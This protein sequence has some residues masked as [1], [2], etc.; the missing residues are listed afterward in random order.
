MEDP[1]SILGLAQ[2]V[3]NSVLLWP[4]QNL[5]AI[6]KKTKINQWDLIK[7]TS[8]CTAN[9]AI[10]KKKA[11]LR[12]GKKIVP[13]Y[14]TDKVFNCKIYKQHTT[15]QQK[16]SNPTEKQAGDLHLCF[17]KKSYR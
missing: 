16:N 17:S 6:G 15:R 5:V 3:K 4:W 8:F 9:E 1:G 12:K 11:N 13:N 7:L 10:K 2:W 14:A